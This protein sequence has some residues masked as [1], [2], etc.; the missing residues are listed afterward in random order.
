MKL[1]TMFLMLS[2]RSVFF[3][4]ISLLSVMLFH[5]SLFE[6]SRWWTILCV[7]VNILTLFVLYLFTRKEG[8]SYLSLIR[9]E[10]KKTKKKQ[11]FYG[12]MIVVFTGLS[13][14]FVA[15]LVMYQT[16]PYL[17]VSL[18]QP[19]PIFVIVIVIILLPITTT[20]AE[21]GLYLGIG[22]NFSKNRWIA[23][24][25]SAFFYAFQHAFIPM[26]LN[27][28]YLMYRFLS[29]LPLT[30]ILAFWYEKKRNPLPIMI[31]HFT[32]NLFTVVQILIFSIF[33][34]AYPS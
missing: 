1:I 6:L 18:V 3:I 5:Q 30:I 13:G 16:F 29:F 7:I 2:I 20:L 33:P 26:I 17:A 27:G 25:L 9:Y 12:I 8:I 19:I 14:M 24:G 15:G 21:D 28:T 4:A 22:I 31:G 11:I 10:K 23:I 34:E 32:I